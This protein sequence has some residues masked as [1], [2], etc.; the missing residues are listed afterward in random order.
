MKR[1]KQKYTE[2]NI[3]N[4]VNTIDNGVICADDKY[5]LSPKRKELLIILLETRIKKL[6]SNF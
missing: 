4:I 6:V 3:S 2:I 1:A 5:N